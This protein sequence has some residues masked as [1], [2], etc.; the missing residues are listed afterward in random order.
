MSFQET[1][2]R[3]HVNNFIAH[4]EILIQNIYDRNHQ[5]IQIKVDQ[6]ALLRFH[7]KYI[8]FFYVVFELKLLQQYVESFEIIEKIDNLTYKF[9]HSQD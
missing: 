3:L 6:G 1:T 4:N 8:I 5:F 9:V 7:K 2:I